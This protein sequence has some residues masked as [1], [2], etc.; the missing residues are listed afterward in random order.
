MKVSRVFA[1]LLLALPAASSAYAAVTLYRGE[2]EL[3]VVSGKGCSEKDKTGNR[4]PINLALQQDG[5]SGQFSGFFS[6]SDIAR[7]Q[8]TGGNL[9][10][11]QV[12]Y[13]DKPS[14]SPGDAL[15]LAPASGGLEG[16]LRE[17]AQTD[18]GGCYFE[19]AVLRLKQEATGS[20]AEAEYLRQGNLFNSEAYFLSGESLLQ[21]DKA[22]AAILDFTKS[23]NLRT[24]VNPR[25]P[26]R[27]SPAV[28]IA[29]AHLVAGR[30][31]KASAVLRDLMQDRS[32]SGDA[33]VK[34]RT[35]AIDSLC[36]E[37]HYLESKAGQKASLRL[38]DLAGH[39]F[40]GLNEVAVP[41]A[42]CYTEIARE[43]ADQEGP[44]SAI[45]FFQ[46]AVQLNPAN[47]DSI[48]GVV[49][50]YLDMESPVEGRAFLHDHTENFI[51]AAGKDSYDTL[52]SYVYASEA[53]QEENNGNLV[54]AEELSREAIKSRPG[55]RILVI[56]LSRILRKEGKHAEARKLLEGGQKACGDEACRKEYGEE[57]AQQDMIERMVKRLETQSR[58]Q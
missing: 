30:E 14:R 44:E 2:M 50:S 27:A 48:T 43:R 4:I 42:A 16:E 22:D 38:M 9:G 17:I 18:P 3:V 33:Q 35:A 6:G 5:S 31:T 57:A 29:I 47:P 32:G 24:K 40:G 54:R 21:S 49:M 8:F 45:E 1:F 11:L 34:L 19:K 37:E 56:T 36:S 10:R 26:D 41:L 53:Q 58:N 13:P 28:S 15:V 20:E 52:L 39:E 51:K 55:E 25:D 7:G 23:L 12:V 46:K